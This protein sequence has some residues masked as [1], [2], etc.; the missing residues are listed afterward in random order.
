[1]ENTTHPPPF[2]AYSRTVA[3]GAQSGR[4]TPCAIFILSSKI[5]PVEFLVV[6]PPGS[7][8]LQAHFWRGAGWG[9]QNHLE[10]RLLDQAQVWAPYTPLFGG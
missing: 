9:R 1:M 2:Q 8:Q 6:D 7:P 3:Q 10:E 5:V 4:F